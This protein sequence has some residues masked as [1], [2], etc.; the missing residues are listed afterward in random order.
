MSL[1]SQNMK[2]KTHN[3]FITDKNNYILM[4]KE[5]KT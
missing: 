2:N 3:S 1:H 5:K 4:K